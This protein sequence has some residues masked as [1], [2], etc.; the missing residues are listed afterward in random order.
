VSESIDRPDL[1]HVKLLV[2]QARDAAE[3][4]RG[5]LDKAQELR[6]EALAAMPD[7]TRLAFLGIT[8]NGA[9][10]RDGHWIFVAADEIDEWIEDCWRSYNLTLAD[11]EVTS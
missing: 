11:D 8:G 4:G 9:V 5:L 3:L 2:A 6:R 7:G 1:S 10:R